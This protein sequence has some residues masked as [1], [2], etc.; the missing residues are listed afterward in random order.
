LRE[1]GLSY[2]HDTGITRHIAAFLQDHDSLATSEDG[3]NFPSRLLFNGGV[4]KSRRLKERLMEV[5][6]SWKPETAE[7]RELGG[8]DDLDIAV[9]SGAAYYGWAK[10]HGGVRIRGGTPC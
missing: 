3:S 7:F 1:I 8:E 10:L 6:L 4:F 9:A 2:E 5:L